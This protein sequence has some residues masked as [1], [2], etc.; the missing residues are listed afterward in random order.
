VTLKVYRDE[1]H[2]QS[3]GLRAQYLYSRDRL[4]RLLD[5]MVDMADDNDF[6]GD[7]DYCV[8]V[9]SHDLDLDPVHKHYYDDDPEKY[10]RL[11]EIKRHWDSEG[12]FTPNAFCVGASLNPILNPNPVPTDDREMVS[13]LQNAQSASVEV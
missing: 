3:R 11:C 12:L 13:R 5:V 6:P 1:D 8:S 9:F 4:K 7:Y 2:P 10:R